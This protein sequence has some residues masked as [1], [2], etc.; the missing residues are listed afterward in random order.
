[1]YSW[2]GC[3]IGAGP[4]H[5]GA[6][7]S[8]TERRRDDAHLRIIGAVF[9]AEVRVNGIV[10][11]ATLAYYETV[12]ADCSSTIMRHQRLVRAQQTVA[13]GLTAT[14]NSIFS[15]ASVTWVTLAV[16][17]LRWRVRSMLRTGFAGFHFHRT[18]E[19]A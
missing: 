12:P 17:S 11:L 19:L 10:L 5:H 3:A 16:G 15:C 2:T 1:M 13:V 14:V 8:K 6:L 4:L 9:A 18:G 7:P